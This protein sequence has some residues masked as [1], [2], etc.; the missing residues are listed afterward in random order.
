MQGHYI[1]RNYSHLV[2]IHSHDELALYELIPDVV[3]IFDL[4]KHGWWWGNSAA[5][6]FWGLD[7]LEQLIDKDL[8]G[9]T[10]GARDRTLQ[11]FE[12]AAK[13]G[14]TIDPW[15]TYPNGKP[16]TLYMRHRAVL[17]GPERH[18]AIIAYIN[19]EVSLGET[20]EN[21]LLVEA[22]RY[23]TVLVTSFTLDGNIV[24]ENPAA[25]GLE[26]RRHTLDI[27]MTRHPL[28]GEFLILVAE[29]DVTDLHAAL[30]EA[31]RAQSELQHLAHH[32]ALTG[33]PSLHY[34]SV[35]AL[36]LLAQAQRH[37]RRARIWIA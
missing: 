20:P 8:S 21:L 15:T 37:E 14:L 29:Y 34:L 31:Q 7:T 23:T 6:R 28:S 11:T 22:M 30:D 9:D 17:V 24:I 18:R 10:Q 27:R 2:H 36:S 16:K 3:W 12:L 26:V 1:E 32:D 33:I 4:D 19:E 35:S 5:L 13:N 25:T